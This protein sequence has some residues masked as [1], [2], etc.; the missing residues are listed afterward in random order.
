[1][2]QPLLELSAVPVYVLVRVYPV[3]MWA[4]YCRIFVASEPSQPQPTRNCF[5][6]ADEFRGQNGWTGKPKSDI[7]LADSQVGLP[8]GQHSTAQHNASCAEV[9][10]EVGRVGC[11]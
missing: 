4:V 10:A 6:K 3:L 9:V 1:M 8:A 7:W 5:S 2:P 11:G